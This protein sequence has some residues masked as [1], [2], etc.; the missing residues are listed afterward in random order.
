MSR[1]LQKIA[2]SARSANDFVH[3]LLD[4]VFASVIPQEPLPV[5][6]SRPIRNGFSSVEEVGGTS[7]IDSYSDTVVPRV[8]ALP[9]RWL[10][11]GSLTE[12]PESAARI[13]SLDQPDRSVG[14][15][16]RHLVTAPMRD[17]AAKGTESSPIANPL[18]PELPA[19]GNERLTNSSIGLGSPMG[20]RRETQATP[21]HVPHASVPQLEPNDITPLGGQE[22]NLPR[23]WSKAQADKKEQ[24][25]PAASLDRKH[26]NVPGRFS[27]N[28]AR[29]PSSEQA[30][31]VPEI[32]REPIGKSLPTLADSIPQPSSSFSGLVK[33]REPSTGPQSGFR[34]PDRVEIHIG[35][36]EVVAVPPP[37]RSIES[38]PVPRS[39]SLSEYLKRGPGRA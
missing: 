6:Q 23:R 7:P 31:K 39:L 9:E 19:S 30:P 35:R 1:Y 8:E 15:S 10:V 4:S 26:E 5:M 28:V 29:I 34:E 12:G 32:G 37:S 25:K 11:P 24:A 38:K 18:G 3:P 27:V 14:A 2:S 16:G 17:D 22:L 36:I 20:D 13:T 21:L 33:R